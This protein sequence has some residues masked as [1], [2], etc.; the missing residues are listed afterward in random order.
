MA[1]GEQTLAELLAHAHW[2]RRLARHLVRESAAADDVVQETWVAAAR[3]RPAP[4]LARGWLARVVRNFSLMHLRG[5]ERRRGRESVAAGVAEAPDHET[6][7]ARMQMQRIVAELVM[8]LEEPYRSTVL[9]RFYEGLNATEI[10]RLQGIEAGTVRWRL[11]LAL[12]RIR[13]ALDEKHQRRRWLVLLAPIVRPNLLGVV[14]MKKMLSLSLVLVALLAG[15]T[16]WQA[17]KKGAGVSVDRSS[18]AGASRALPRGVPLISTS[19]TI[20]GRVTTPEGAPVPAAAV[21]VSAILR[22]AEGQET[23]VLLTATADDRGAFRFA[24]LERGRY[25]LTATSPDLTPVPLTVELS[26]G[27]TRSVQLA[28]RRGGHRLSGRIL[29]AGAGTIPGARLSALISA[30][31]GGPALRFV[32]FA[33]GNG[34]YSLALPPGQYALWAEADG[35]ARGGQAVTLAG[36]STADFQLQPDAQLLGRVVLKTT[37]EPVPEAE[38]RAFPAAQYGRWHP[39]VSTDADGLFRVPS[40]EGGE[41]IVEARRGR[42]V[43][44]AH[45]AVVVAA[46]A[47]RGLEV[48][49]EAAAL[50]EGRVSAPDGRSLAG[51]H[52]MAARPGTRVSSHAAVADDGSFRLEGVL[53]GKYELSAGSGDGYRGFL[54]VVVEDRDLSGLQ[55]ALAAPIAVTG[56]VTDATGTPIAGAR[57]TVRTTGNE[58]A[59][60]GRGR[61]E[62]TDGA[63]TFRVTGLPAGPLTV[64]ATREGLAAAS[65]GPEPVPPG[66]EAT[67]ELRLAT[68]P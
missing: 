61:I 59:R 22:P 52:V 32:A 16:A 60:W 51:I 66:R 10:G 45:P 67:V 9:L 20:D 47:T 28:L 57:V 37:R 14:L 5:E 15:V 25:V 29:D 54:Q 63:G 53:P 43:G 65:W 1:Q 39:A 2:M 23:S 6:L 12:D 33:D 68:P 3:H 62:V 18:A 34:A 21:A 17:R 7:L 55:I 64:S 46:R 56:R 35:Y 36:D 8:E 50:L 41:W 42:L 38:V 58:V 44:V 24:T 40:L 26:P 48:E 27:E 13:A 4:D 19:A 31:S 49:L 11:K 30:T